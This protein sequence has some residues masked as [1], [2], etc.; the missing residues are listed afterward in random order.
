M[1]LFFQFFSSFLFYVGSLQPRTSCFPLWHFIYHMHNVC[2]HEII[3]ENENRRE[4]T[5]SLL[6]I[7]AKWM[8]KVKCTTWILIS[9]FGIWWNK[10]RSDLWITIEIPL[11]SWIMLSPTSVPVPTFKWMSST[12]TPKMKMIKKAYR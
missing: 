11:T 3:P 6:Q 9:V 2:R 5:G 8:Q 4:G 10:S 7:S 1:S 12:Y